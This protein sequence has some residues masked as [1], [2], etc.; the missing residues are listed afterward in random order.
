MANFN[1]IGS[2]EK[3]TNFKNEIESKFSDCNLNIDYRI[4][5][6]CKEAEE[7]YLDNKKMVKEIQELKNN[8]SNYE[9]LKNSM[10][11]SKNEKIQKFRNL[12]EN[13]SVDLNSENDFYR[14]NSNCSQIKENRIEYENLSNT[15]DKNK[16]L[17]TDIKKNSILGRKGISY[18]HNS[19]KN[20][21]KRCL[22]CRLYLNE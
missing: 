15:V 22:A 12:D 8:I 13:S 14:R 9:I 17:N 10:N 16:G 19:N 4:L 2:R 6:V 5:R 7:K 3:L 20:R 18:S 21:N 1:Y 11:K